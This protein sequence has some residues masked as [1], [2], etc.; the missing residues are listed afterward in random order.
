MDNGNKQSGNGALV[1]GQRQY[2]QRLDVQERMRDG[3]EVFSLGYI[4][5][6]KVNKRDVQYR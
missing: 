2:T 5:K 1:H 6:P 3:I 4:S